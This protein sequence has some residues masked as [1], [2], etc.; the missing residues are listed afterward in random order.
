MSGESA[1]K[2]GT[3][4]TAQK[5]EGD[6]STRVILPPSGGGFRPKGW[7]GRF[8][9]RLD[10]HLGFGGFGSVYVGTRLNP[11]QPITDGETTPPETV[12]V[13]VFHSDDGKNPLDSMNR[14]L[15]ALLALRHHRIPRIYDWGSQD[16]G[17]FIVMEFCPSG[18]LRTALATVGQ[19]PEATLLRLMQD[20]LE[21]M[22]AAHA[23]SLLHLD[24]KPSNILLDGAGGFLLTDFGLA[25]AISVSGKAGSSLGIGTRG[26]QSPEQS[27]YR[28]DEFDSRTDLWGLGAT[29]W[30]LATGVDLTRDYMIPRQREADGEDHSLPPIEMWRPRFPKE[31]SG[32]INHMTAVAKSDRPGGAMEVLNRVRSFTRGIP[33]GSDAEAMKRRTRISQVEVDQVISSLRDPLLASIAKAFEFDQFIV[34]FDD[35]EVV[36]KEGETAAYAF[37]LLAGR[38]VVERGGKVLAAEEREGTFFGEV[39]TLTGSTRTAGIRA[40][41]TTYAAIFNQAQLEHLI[42]LNPPLALRLVKLLAERVI[43]ESAR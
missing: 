10:R 27:L 2:H 26:Y 34:R 37:L 5:Q 19:M 40:I 35:G 21:A 11:I 36:F 38:V 23:A 30:A 13:K 28:L 39:A 29:L 16:F 31:L 1:S 32:L 9:Y 20:M 7:P 22:V 17:H 42:A 24:I 12:A 3:P 6:D 15:A 41:G 4:N 25:E 43:R 33:L 14:E 8:N 18:S